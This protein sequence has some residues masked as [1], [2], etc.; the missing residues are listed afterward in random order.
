MISY[1]SAVGNINGV[2]G[3]DGPAWALRFL[4]ISAR[5]LKVTNEYGAYNLAITAQGSPDT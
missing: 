3:L 1:S 4:Y 5:L 2:Q